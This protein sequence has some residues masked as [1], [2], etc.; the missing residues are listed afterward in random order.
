MSDETPVVPVA[1]PAPVVEAPKEFIFQY[2][3]KDE[4]GKPLGAPQVIKATNP[5]EAL[6][7]MAAQNSELVKLNRKL[8]K[9]IRL[10]NIVQDEIPADAPRF[11]SAQYDFNPK[12]LTAED[13]LQLTQDLNDPEKC[14]SAMDRLISARI[15]D[16]EAI[17]QTLRQ[18]RQEIATMHALAQAEAFV[19]ST[20]EY[21]GCE[22]NKQTLG[23]WMIKNNLDPILKNFKL[24]F[25]T[26]G[27]QGANIL[28]E[29]PV[30]EAPKPAPVVE[31]QSEP[32]PVVVAPRPVSSGLTRTNSSDAG[33]PMKT[34]Y[35]AAEIEKMS[36]EE[37]KQK[38]LIP[39]FRSQR[40]RA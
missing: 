12:P 31:P 16:P 39:Q 34:G 21:Y 29:R 38:V 9:D 25:T 37:Y 11:N 18:T 20:P 30:P 33:T 13:R 22:E 26:L 32:A 10:G 19:K 35:S 4:E 24:A 27:P 23:S 1:D 6:E 40:Q 15:G 36:G 28:K 7:K 8:N 5:E 2:Q 14:D 3:P 17:R